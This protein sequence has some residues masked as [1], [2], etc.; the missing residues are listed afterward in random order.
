M[1]VFSRLPNLAALRAFEAAARHGNFSRAAEEMHVTHGAISHQVRG[2]EDDLGVA[3]FTRNGKRI[4]LTAEGQQ[5]ALRV[6]HALTDLVDATALMRA[7]GGQKRLTITALPSFAAR[8]LSPRLG[9][10]IESH[11]E[12]EVALQSSSQI[13]DLEHGDIDIAIRFGAGVYP[14]LCSEL[15]MHDYYYPVASPNFL[16]GSLPSTPK[17]LSRKML[18]RCDLEPWLP[19]FKAAGLARAEPTGG[20]IYQDS[21][22]LIRAAVDGEGIALARHAIAQPDIASGQL[23]RLF[24]VSIRCPSSYFLVYHERAL[25]RAQVAEFRRWI[26]AEV[27][28][29]TPFTQR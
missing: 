1:S 24:D 28:G 25:E 14:D 9:G 19:W 11:P 20:L 7:R 26:L 12:L 10:Y 5:L 13:A 22:M 29:L 3:L 18:L 4:A 2:L 6:R 8:W 16:G 23:V 21:S 15:L 17:E 27:A